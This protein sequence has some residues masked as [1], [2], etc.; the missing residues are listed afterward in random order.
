LEGHRD[1]LEGHLGVLEGH[2][3]VLEGH[4]GVL[5]SHLD[6]LES[7]LDVLEA[8]GGVVD[9]DF[10]ARPRGVRLRTGKVSPVGMTSGA[11][12]PSLCDCHDGAPDPDDPWA[13]CCAC[14][15]MWPS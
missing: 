15:G 8:H 10:G 3:D 14:T 13:C 1:V 12:L 4:L 11:R 9:G 2:R 5:E 6:V 7:H